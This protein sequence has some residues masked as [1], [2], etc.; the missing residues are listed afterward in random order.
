[1]S[2]ATAATVADHTALVERA[3]RVEAQQEVTDDQ[4]SA[5]K[6]PAVT[7]GTRHA[8]SVTT[9][10]AESAW[11]LEDEGI[12]QDLASTDEQSANLGSFFLFSPL[13]GCCE[14]DDEDV[15]E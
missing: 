10:S 1:M 11:W 5:A 6:E 9:A 4:T 15:Y 7:A 14:P 2:S 8:D 3:Q 12:A 13:F